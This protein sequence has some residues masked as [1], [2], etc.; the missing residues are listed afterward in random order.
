[1][2]INVLKIPDITPTGNLIL[3]GNKIN[4]GLPNSII[5]ILATTTYVAT[6]NLNIKD[7]IFELNINASTLSAFDIGDLSGFEILGTTNTGFMKTTTDAKRY[8]IKAPNDPNTNYI[9][10][11]DLNNN[12]II[13]G[14]TTIQN[15][16]YVNLN[17]TGSNISNFN[18]V[19]INS[20][21]YVFDKAITT[22]LIKNNN[23]L[24]YIK[25]N[26][27]INNISLG[28]SL[29][30][31]ANSMLNT[32]TIQSTL[33]I[34]SVSILNN[35]LT[36]NNYLNVSNNTLIQGL[37]TNRKSL[38]INNNNIINGSSS[39]LSKLNINR[40]TLINQN[41]TGLQNLN[42]AISAQVNKKV[43]VN[44]SL[45][46]GGNSYLYGNNTIGSKIGTINI[47]GSILC[48]IPEY[49]DNTTAQLNNLPIGSFYRTGGILKI[50]LNTVPPIMTLLGSTTITN[51]L[52]SSFIDPG[53][54]AIDNENNVLPVYITFIGSGNNNYINNNILISG[55]NTLI[56]ST[57]LLSL[58][59]NMI[60]Y[61]ST[62]VN[63]N[64]NNINRILNVI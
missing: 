40:N 22:S 36:I 1:M 32:T 11:L 15:N 51:I 25:N 46:V 35:N 34:S 31:N 39:F 19:T 56:T 12:I 16:G 59:S 2:N 58:G 63:G 42:I 60:T 13:S 8:Q 44:S 52:G 27:I 64:I 61:T 3:Q 9:L 26:T 54:Y 28:S 47:L 53:V 33:Y 30:I 55:P 57:S 21:L 4:L 7:K 17:L 23:S 50:C 48:K 5:N 37:C 10:T 24:L 29:L 43:S 45:L 41:T 20:N 14:T 62:D 6:Q 49:E 18:N 38:Y